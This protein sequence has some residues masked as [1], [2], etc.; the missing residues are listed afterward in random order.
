MDGTL[1][2]ARQPIEQNMVYAI[3][4]LLE[5]HKVGIVTGSDLNYIK[6]QCSELF[7]KC[8]NSRTH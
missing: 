5:K 1:T 6:E 2:K 7:N 8:S 4:T 3:K